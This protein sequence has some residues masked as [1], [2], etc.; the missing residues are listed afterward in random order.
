MVCHTPPKRLS[1][2]LTILQDSWTNNFIHVAVARL[3]FCWLSEVSSLAHQRFHRW[4]ST[5]D[6]WS[7]STFA[8]FIWH[9]M[10]PV[11]HT[12]FKS[13]IVSMDTCMWQRSALCSYHRHYC[14]DPNTGF[15]LSP[16]W[17]CPLVVPNPTCVGHSSNQLGNKD[18]TSSSG[19]VRESVRRRPIL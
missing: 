19:T 9:R 6:C 13:S 10:Y 12:P 7:S 16:A 3:L 15:P 5:V 8:D 17:N 14:P 1:Q 18:G 11:S 2:L 4:P